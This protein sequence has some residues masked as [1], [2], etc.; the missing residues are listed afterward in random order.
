[1]NIIVVVCIVL[2]IG[3]AIGRKS[4]EQKDKTPTYEQESKFATPINKAMPQSITELNTA[5]TQLKKTT[6]VKNQT[7]SIDNI[8]I[9]EE[10]EK[11]F[12]Q[13][14]Y[15]DHNFFVTGKAGTGKSVLLQYFVRHTAKQAVIVAP[16]G[17]AAINVGGQT[18]HSFFGLAPEIQDTRD[19]SQ[20]ED[21][22]IKKKRML[23]NLRVLVI[24]EI[25]MVRADVMDM[26][27]AK[28]QYARNSD[29]PFGGCQLIVFGDLYQL[30][31]VVTAGKEMAFLEH[32]YETV[33]FFG[34]KA[35]ANHP[36]RIIELQTIHRQKVIEKDDTNAAFINILNS[37]RLGQCNE[38]L[39]NYINQ[40]CL[41]E[42]KDNRYITITGD[43][44]TANAINLN[45]LSS[46]PGKEYEYVAD[47]D[48]RIIK[49]ASMP[50]DPILK[51]KVGALVMM[52]KNDHM[53]R[54]QKP[55][56]VNG[57]LAIV[58]TLT[59]NSIVVDIDGVSHNV[60][61]ETWEKCE[62]DYDSSTRKLEKKVV[63]T[64]TQYPIKLAYAVTIHKSQGQTFDAVKVDLARGAFAA[65]QTYVALSRCRS[66]ESLYL[67]S[68]L[69]LKDIW[70]NPDVVKYMVECGTE[71]QLN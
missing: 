41:V 25:S 7:I 39:I 20:V 52:I 12:E 54:Q 40:Q 53:D 55:R 5:N 50:A 8:I 24:D 32:Q 65:G 10:Q 30:P 43:N 71:R 17:I 66:I 21:L 34:A 18:I 16:T 45:K 35:V 60:E 27:D 69:K 57:T 47:F 70:V 1:M 51:L 44:N 29:L 13:L 46:L 31:P 19:R 68:P 11:A 48:K 56:W 49:Q 9:D 4:G 59:D 61:K 58:N 63:A 64:F 15:N 33:F 2:L 38:K 67:A 26:I 42:P 14:E 28:L 22:S 3:I 62:Y 23:Q 36:F 37:I 6:G